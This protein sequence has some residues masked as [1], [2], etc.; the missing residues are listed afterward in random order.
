MH[1]SYSLLTITLAIAACALAQQ[2]AVP[3]PGPMLDLPSTDYPSVSSFFANG[4]EAK[5][6]SVAAQISAFAASQPGAAGS[7]LMSEFAEAT[8]ALQS[9]YQNPPAATNAPTPAS[10]NSPE[11]PQPHSAAQTTLEFKYYTV[12]IAILLLTTVVIFA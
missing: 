3:T 9:I 7:S 8:K 5:M 12:A 10:S 6:S 11:N 4:G 2:S 1:T